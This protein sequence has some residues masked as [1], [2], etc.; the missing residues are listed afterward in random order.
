MKKVTSPP[1]AAVHVCYHCGLTADIK[2]IIN[3]DGKTFCCQGCLGAFRLIHGLGLETY[4]E[5]RTL[6]GSTSLLV[7]ET[8]EQNVAA[9]DDPEVQREMVRDVPG[10][11]KEA[12]L[13]LEGIHCAACVW[14]NEQILRRVPGVVDAQ[15]NFANFRATVQWNPQQTSLSRLILALGRVG[16]KAHPYDTARVEQVT[17]RRDRAFLL[18]LG[19][20]GFGAANIMFIAVALYAGAFQGME[21]QYRTFFHWVSLIIAIPVVFYSGSVFFQG[22]WRGIRAG[23]L[24]MDFSIALGAGVTFVAS[25]I[26]T[27]GGSD[28]VYFDSVTIFIFVLLL[29][30]T[31]ESL[32]R[33]KAAGAAE[34]LTGFQPDTAQVIRDGKEQRLHLRDVRVGDEVVVRP[35]EKI[36]VDGWV[37]RGRTTV[38]ESM[39]TGEAVPVIKV[40]GSTVAGGS[41]N[42]EGGIHVRVRRM[43]TETTLARILAAVVAAQSGR[44]LAHGLADRIA[45]RFAGTVVILA[46]G[47]FALWWWLDPSQAMENAVS[48]LIIT[49]PCALGLATPAALLV[50]CGVAARMGVLIR[51]P[52]SLER[53]ARIQ[54]LV[55]DK[56]GVVTEGKPLVTQCCPHP[57]AGIDARQL[58]T[59]AAAVERYSEHP[60]GRAVLKAYEEQNWGALPE[61]ENAKNQ[62]GLGL[63]AWVE[64]CETRVGRPEFVLDSEN[65]KNAK[66]PVLDNDQP[67]TWIACAVE[68]KLWGWLGLE[69]KI[70]VDA[71]ATVDFLR[72]KGL[73]ITLLSGDRQP[74][75]DWTATQI[76]VHAAIGGVLPE[77]KL[78]TIRTMQ[79]QGTKEVAMVGDGLNDAPA[80][81]LAD[82]GMAVE[83]A[84]DL[85]VETSDVILLNPGLNS[86]KFVF[87]LAWATLRVIRQNLFFSLGYN[88]VTIPLAMA[89]L[90]SPI[91]AAIAMP[92]SSLVVVANALRLQRIVPNP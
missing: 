53:L 61:A 36:A 57:E 25:V 3:Q 37:I 43:G 1:E 81:A 40:E 10:G 11:L 20:A 5:R 28:S 47:T 45:G 70:K 59:R 6:M 22:A 86:V 29:G 58:L 31:L 9:F 66:P 39:L 18:R 79:A 56:T 44:N 51:D 27:L 90:V 87:S 33:S 2:A 78:Q 55:L 60:L 42:V 19:V 26:A 82:V 32:A 64:G 84:A 62:P 41:I 71:Q 63:S 23:H 88:A 68:G 48:L 89:G 17:R 34:R 12:H 30:R 8:Q 91:V 69:D 67:V 24:T 92:I 76:G 73:T 77:E 50:A 74:T 85:S 54:Q 65:A 35:G 83:R 72:K 75:V 46:V 7:D 14:L 49:C 80:L 21:T 16:Y 15:V 4:Y 13:L 38:D 52:G